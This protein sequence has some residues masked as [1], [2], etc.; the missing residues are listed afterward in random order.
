M[1]H[2]PVLSYCFM[3][4]MRWDNNTVVN[5]DWHRAQ[6]CNHALHYPIPLEGFMLVGGKQLLVCLKW[7]RELDQEERTLTRASIHRD[8]SLV[9]LDHAV[10]D[11]KTKTCPRTHLLGGNAI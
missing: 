9:V 8:S 11:G 2:G 6:A 7:Y 3:C 10:G 5:T 4:S 1:I